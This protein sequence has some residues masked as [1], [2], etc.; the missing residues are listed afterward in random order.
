MTT[1]DDYICRYTGGYPVFT[2]PLIKR[3][4]FNDKA[5]IVFW[6]DGT[7]TVVKLADGDIYDKRIALLWAMAKRGFMFRASSLNRYLDRWIDEANE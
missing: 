4:I 3:V 1:F 5:T 7:K 2:I 6:V